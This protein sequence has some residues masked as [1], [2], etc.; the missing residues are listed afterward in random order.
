MDVVCLPL[1]RKWTFS[2]SANMSDITSRVATDLGVSDKNLVFFHPML[3]HRIRKPMNKM[4][5]AVK[6]QV[7]HKHHA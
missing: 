6:M 3:Q 5:A 4:R 1:D 7:C 2:K